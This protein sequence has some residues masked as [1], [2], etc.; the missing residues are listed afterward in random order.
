M[1]GGITG[2]YS[3]NV[4]YYSV[5]IRTAGVH[6]EIRPL[7]GRF[8]AI[9]SLAVPVPNS[10]L[11][12]TKQP[13]Q[14]RARSGVEMWNL[15]PNW[16]RDLN[17]QNPSKNQSSRHSAA[18]RNSDNQTPTD[19]HHEIS[20]AGKEVYVQYRSRHLQAGSAACTGTLPAAARAPCPPLWPTAAS[21]LSKAWGQ[22][23]NGS[24]RR[25]KRR[26]GW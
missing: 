6:R 21:S 19:H 26:R 16:L 25:W 3:R 12:P 10:R 22:N 23:R 5:P 11:I 4:R 14:S 13:G 24:R 1:R 18:A 8:S 9:W 7:L 20:N 2:L 15:A 17:R